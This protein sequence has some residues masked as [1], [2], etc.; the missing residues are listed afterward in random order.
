MDFAELRRGVRRT[1]AP[2]PGWPSRGAVVRDVLLW[3]GMCLVILAEFPAWSVQGRGNLD[4]VP[5]AVVLAGVIVVLSRTYPLAAPCLALA[6]YLWGAASIVV[7]L[8]CVSYLAGRRADRGWV[9]V[10][11]F[12]AISVFL[13]VWA[14][15]RLDDVP[16]LLINSAGVLAFGL[17]LPWLVGVYRRQ[18][19]DLGAAGWEHARQLQLEQRLTE[20]QAR[21]RERSR[22]AQDMHDSLGHEL[23]LI[24]L[25][26]G[27]LEVSPDLGERHRQEVGELRATAVSA[28]A[29]L[30][31]II[32][33]LRTGAESEPAPTT[34][35]G[36]GVSVLVERARDSGV[37]VSLAQEGQLDALPPMV[38][39]AVYRVVQE[40]LTNATK[41]APGARVTVWL[42][43]DDSRLEVRVSN[44]AGGGGGAEAETGGGRGLTGLR[45][46]VRMTG[47]TF[48]VGPGGDGWEVCAVMPLDGDAVAEP[49]DGEEEI[50][51][52]QRAA[53]RK[54]QPW[55]VAL[56]VVPVAVVALVIGAVYYSLHLAMVDSTLPPEDYQSISAGDSREDLEGVLPES[57]LGL[58]EEQ[59]EPF[60]SGDPSC[61]HYRGTSGMFDRDVA[62]YQLCFGD[63]VLETKE[64]LELR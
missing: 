41:Y 19:V 60:A 55:T 16:G 32:G 20:E 21:L 45:E 26:A 27:A 62:F 64:R 6:V 2:A 17:A 57:T 39:R 40:S 29:H 7:L 5:V 36:E 33:V 59:L 24:A 46:R 51:E 44:S 3:L 54:V 15:P 50:D 58:E 4:L 53:D 38:D 52:L 35:A 14:V 13:T 12:A 10:A 43:A 56:V 30:R 18:H 42:T 31:E 48:A 49:Q 61:D 22:I 11:L 25:Q 37:R 9:A 28:T 1:L 8:A 63:G 34:P 23:S 47:G